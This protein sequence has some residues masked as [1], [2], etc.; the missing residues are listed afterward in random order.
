MYVPVL[1]SPYLPPSPSSPPPTPSHV[2]K[3]VFNVCLHCCSANRFHSPRI[4]AT[5]NRSHLG[6]SL[7]GP[8]K[9]EN[10]GPFVQQFLRISRRQPQ[11]IKLCGGPCEV[12]V[13]LARLHLHEASSAPGGHSTVPSAL[14]LLLQHCSSLCEM[15]YFS[16]YKKKSGH[17]GANVDIFNRIISDYLPVN[18]TSSIETMS[19]WRTME[20]S[21]I[22]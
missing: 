19:I 9:N 3:S 1:L 2:H 5:G 13:T 16:R 20:K 7:P 6:F 18:V 21:N 22:H 8:W 15:I 11:G 12:P 14:K 4:L 10:S 17:F